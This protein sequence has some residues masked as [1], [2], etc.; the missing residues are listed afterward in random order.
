MIARSIIRTLLYYEIFDHP[1][2]AD[3]LCHFI[4]YPDV[5]RSEIADVLT[6][7]EERGVIRSSHGFYFRAVNRTDLGLLRLERE[8]LAR[9]RWKIARLMTRIIRRFPFVRGVLVSGDLSKGVATPSSDVDYLVITAPG[10]LWI[11]RAL[12]MAFKKICLLNSRKYFCLNHYVDENHLTHPERN[13]YT[14]TEVAHLKPLFN[15]PLFLRYMGANNWIRGYFPNFDAS[16]ADLSNAVDSK[17]Y[18]QPVLEMFLS[19]SWADRLEGWLMHLMITVWKNRYPQYDDE[20]RAQIF[21]STEFESRAYVGNFSSRIMASYRS[22]LDDF[23]GPAEYHE[24]HLYELSA[25]D[26]NG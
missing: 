4:S 6:L 20:T 23:A 5:T 10:R 3:E 13:Y 21:R 9:R 17:S 25:L 8:Q 16:D 14:A 24:R 18:L 22:K 1:L 15:V 2:S 7:L 26:G 19:G 11:C 12:L